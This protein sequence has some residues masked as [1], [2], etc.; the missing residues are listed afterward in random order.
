[1]QLCASRWA[2][3]AAPRQQCRSPAVAAA[4]RPRPQHGAAAAAAGGSGS[5]GSP[6]GDS[7]GDSSSS[8]S[9]SSSSGSDGG[10]RGR[11]RRMHADSAALRAQLSS[12]GLAGVVAYG[13]LNTLY[14]CAAFAAAFT[15]ADVPHGLGAQAA[16][17]EAAKV[18]GLVWAGSQ[19]TKLLRAG[20][21]LALAP[22]VDRGLGVAVERLRLRSKGQ[23][24]ALVVGG[25]LALAAAVFGGVVAAHA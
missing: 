5:A 14:Y 7:A 20:G 13:L 3:G 16:A 15:F 9:T 8:S 19:V 1:M 10:L 17:R 11:W 21:A 22:A 23:A 18:L 24:F 12:Y 25:C 4:A 2:A 6:G